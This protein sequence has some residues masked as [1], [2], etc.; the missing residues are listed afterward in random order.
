LIARAGAAESN[1]ITESVRAGSWSCSARWHVW[2]FLAFR[3]LFEKRIDGR[4][5]RDL[6]FQP[7]LRK[8][9]TVKVA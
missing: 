9:E 3:R 7:A 8:H 6:R 5:N 2:Q 4:A 1:V